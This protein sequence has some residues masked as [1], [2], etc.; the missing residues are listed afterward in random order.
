MRPAG[1]K[2]RQHRRQEGV[3]GEGER[4]SP[5]LPDDGKIVTREQGRTPQNQ[6]GKRPGH[7]CPSEVAVPKSCGHS[8]LLCPHWS[9]VYSEP[10][11]LGDPGA[12]LPPGSQQQRQAQRSR[13]PKGRWGE[14]AQK[15]GKESKMQRGKQ[16]A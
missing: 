13:Q 1:R 4:A 2:Q 14:M 7:V 12:P 8:N 11:A 3:E 6:E 16:L 10:Q 15:V 9:F 5:S